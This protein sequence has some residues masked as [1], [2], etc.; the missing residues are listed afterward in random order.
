MTKSS[1][2]IHTRVQ[3]GHLIVAGV[4]LMLSGSVA[5]SVFAQ[6][7]EFELIDSSVCAD[8]HEASAHGSV[9]AEDIAHSAHDGLECL[10][11]HMDMGTIEAFSQRFIQY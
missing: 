10:D 6:E 8:C 3:T 5:G 7:D 11:C 4:A 1:A 2:F 9:F